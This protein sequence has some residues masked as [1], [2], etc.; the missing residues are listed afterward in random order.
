MLAYCQTV[1]TKLFI[2]LFWA[3]R[4]D[5]GCIMFPFFIGHH[6]PLNLNAPHRKEKKDEKMS[7]GIGGGI[8]VSAR[9]LYGF[10]SADEQ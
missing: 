9:L 1:F 8:T 6:P 5:R 10:D 4:L 3:K 7:D 2:A